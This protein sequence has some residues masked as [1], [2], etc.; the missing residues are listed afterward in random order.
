MIFPARIEG[1]GEIRFGDHASLGKSINLGIAHQAKL[2]IGNNFRLGDHTEI[3]IGNE[4]SLVAG[5]NCLIEE[6]TR[7][8]IGN[9]WVWGDDVSFSTFCQVFSREG[10]YTGK[11]MI[12][13][14]SHIGD[15]T[16]ID[17]AGD[18]IIGKK[19]ALGPNCV[20]YSHDHIYDNPAKAAWEGG[21]TTGPIH[22]ED[23]AWL[24]SGVTV[25][26]GVTIGKNTVVAAGSV[27]TKSLDANCIYGGVPAKLLKQITY[28]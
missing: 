23:G 22:I 25:L 18:V 17:V 4:L 19:V 13:D 14:D 7:I 10:G 11:L 15:H 2:Q 9:N 3:I 5:N 20:L 24:G 27:V 16:I 12:D 1:S 8:Y 21:V 26:P 6:G 28:K